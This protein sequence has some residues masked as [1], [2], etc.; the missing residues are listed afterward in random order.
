[1]ADPA[2]YRTRE[3]EK[4]W[5]ATRDPIALFEQKLK[6]AGL[7]RD[8][9]IRATNDRVDAEIEDIARFADESPEPTLDDL[10][11]DIT[12]EGAGAIAWRTKPSTPRE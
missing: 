5:K 11:S 1:M 10:Y 7:I 12:V 4:Q 3:E 6:D 2:Y 9:D 8:E